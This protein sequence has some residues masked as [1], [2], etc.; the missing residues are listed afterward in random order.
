[1][2]PDPKSPAQ[3]PDGRFEGPVAFQQAVRDALACAVQFGWRELVISD[4]S[5]EDW[6]LHERT[7]AESLQAWSRSGRK[8]TMVAARY[9]AVVRNQARFVTW[10]QRWDH[11]IVCRVCRHRDPQD[12]PSVIWSPE[13]ALRRLDLVR[14]TG[15]CSSAAVR[16]TRIREELDEL[17]A[18][19]SPGFP[20]ST[21]GL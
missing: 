7:V 20:A 4:A 6:P 17:L 8:L 5:F 3:L 1:M 10:R 19:S 15:V 11:I 18:I 9:D 13:W 21:L 12:F 2:Q 16:R 14:S